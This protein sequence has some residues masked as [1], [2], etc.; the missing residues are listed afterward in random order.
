MTAQHAGA[1]ESRGSLVQTQ[2]LFN[3]VRRPSEKACLNY[4]ERAEVETERGCIR[5]LDRVPPQRRAS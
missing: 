2:Y 4:K 5:T 1:G 3:E